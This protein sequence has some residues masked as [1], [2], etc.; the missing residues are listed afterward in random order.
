ME[1]KPS[2]LFTLVGGCTALISPGEQGQIFGAAIVGAVAGGFVGAVTLPWPTS[3]SRKDCGKRKCM[4]PG[5][6]DCRIVIRKRWAANLCV[7]AT[8]GPF[9]ALYVAPKF[10]DQP[11]FFLGLISG[12]AFGDL[13]VILLTI[14]VPFLVG[15]VRERLDKSK[16]GKPNE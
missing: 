7:G 14:A 1:T 12:A 4:K 13:G 16:D 11:P 8:C 2:I 6:P 10:P 5:C 9:F 3:T 15:K